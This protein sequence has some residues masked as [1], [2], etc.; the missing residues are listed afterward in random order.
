MSILVCYMLLY[1][2]V[3]MKMHAPTIFSNKQSCTFCCKLGSSVCIKM[4]VIS[5]YNQTNPKKMNKTLLSKIVLLE[6]RNL[7]CKD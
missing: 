1:T 4:A 3:Y 7:K 6:F 2:N 5:I